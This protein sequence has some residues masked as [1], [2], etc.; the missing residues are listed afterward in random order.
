MISSTFLL[1]YMGSAFTV[2][3]RLEITSALIFLLFLIGIPW[4]IRKYN[5]FRI[6]DIIRI[7]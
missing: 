2:G 4:L 5:L 1:T 3:M 6:Q 7:K